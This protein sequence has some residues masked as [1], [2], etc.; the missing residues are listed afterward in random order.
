M[1]GV[2]DRVE[3]TGVQVV[4]ALCD[5]SGVGGILGF[6]IRRRGRFVRLSIWSAIFP[7]VY[8]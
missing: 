6:G 1:V 8:P 7:S 5:I 3:R 4:L 2:G